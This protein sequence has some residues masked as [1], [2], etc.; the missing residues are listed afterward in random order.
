VSGLR[1]HEIAAQARPSIM[2]TELYKFPNGAA[3]FAGFPGGAD[4]RGHLVFEVQLPS[5]PSLYGEFGPQWVENKN[6]YD[7]EIVSFGFDSRNNVANPHPG[8]RRRFSSQQRKIIEDLIVALVSSPEAQRKVPPFA[9][10][11]SRFLGRIHFLP[12]WIIVDG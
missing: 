1:I 7:I 4:E 5:Y 2:G 11:G 12:G 8:A 3:R 9:F 10:E 6:D